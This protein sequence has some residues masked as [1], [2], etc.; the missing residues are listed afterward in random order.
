MF[1]EELSLVEKEILR[2]LL[3]KLDILF[4][5]KYAD[6]RDAVIDREIALCKVSLDSFNSIKIEDLEDKYKPKH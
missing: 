1:R 4:R 3:N 2:D 5:I 6:D